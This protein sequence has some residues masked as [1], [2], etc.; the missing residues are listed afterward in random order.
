MRRI[1]ILAAAAAVLAASGGRAL[2]WESATT[3]AGLTEQAALASRIHLRMTEQFGYASGLYETLVIPPADA[4]SLFEVLHDLLNPTH[5][6]TPDARG[7]LSALGWLVAGAVVADTPAEHATQHFY[8]PRTGKGLSRRTLNGALSR[9]RHR[10]ASRVIRERIVS[11]GMPALGWLAHPRNPMNIHGF[12]SQYVKAV[13]A[14]T[15]GERSRHMAGTLLAAG[16]MLHVLFDMASPSHVRDDLAAHLEVLSD[17]D[18]TDV[19]SRFERVAS[20]AYGRLG[21]PAAGEA[22]SRPSWRAYVTDGDGK[23]LA[24]LTHAR[25]YSAST[26]PAPLALPIKLERG[27]LERRVAA[28]LAKLTPGPKLT[29]DQKRRMLVN[30]RGVCVADVLLEPRQ[31]SF[32]IGDDCALEQLEVILPEAAGYGAGFLDTLLGASLSITGDQGNL[33]IAAEGHDLGPGTILMLWDDRRGVRKEY[34]KQPVSG[35]TAGTLLARV[36]APPA[37]ATRVIALYEGKVG[38]EAVLA[39]QNVAF[40]IVAPAAPAEP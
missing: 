29:L 39:T 24:D 34:G 23:G 4:R 37:G 5:G 31:V 26:L 8:D 32:E 40:P 18:R 20:L 30:E 38:N 13:V 9:L 15:P 21:V 25:W 19:G 35:A 17:E 33:A 27:E 16:A 28:H 2:A 22:V 7:R 12:R 6:Y 14:A 10:L 11:S 3:S 1:A 36:P